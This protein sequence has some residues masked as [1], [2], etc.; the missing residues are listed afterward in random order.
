MIYFSLIQVY[1]QKYVSKNLN[2]YLSDSSGCGKNT[3]ASPAQGST[4][5]Q[6][7]PLLQWTN[8]PLMSLQWHSRSYSRT[9]AKK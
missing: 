2:L 8:G 1:Y 6:M 5:Q 9:L 4:L 7:L 3:T